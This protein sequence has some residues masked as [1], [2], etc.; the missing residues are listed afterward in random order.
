V[1]LSLL[2]PGPAALQ[3]P[4]D[5]LA[6]VDGRFLVPALGGHGLRA[7]VCR[8]ALDTAGLNGGGSNRDVVA[9]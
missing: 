1:P 8:N 6:R 4:G 7:V 9:V 2:E 5:E 3:A